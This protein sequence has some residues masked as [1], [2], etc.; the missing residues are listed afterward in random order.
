MKDQGPTQPEIQRIGRYLHRI[1]PIFD[2][3]GRLIQYA[4]TPLMVELHPRDVAQ[5]AVGASVLA[6]PTALAEEAWRLGATLPL[7]N[8]LGLFVLSIIFVSVFVYTNFYRGQFHQHWL[9]CLA[10]IAIT[11]LLSA[12]VVGILLTLLQQSPWGVDNLV[13]IKRI[14]LVT[15]PA[16]LSGTISDTLR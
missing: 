7:P 10:R 9:Q 4:V 14:I 8:I 15:L 2:K 6:I 3:S 16:S 1:T 12:L 11:Y 13:A 5:I